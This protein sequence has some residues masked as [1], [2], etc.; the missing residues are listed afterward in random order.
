MELQAESAENCGLNIIHGPRTPHARRLMAPLPLNV[1]PVVLHR[2]P[3]SISVSV[4]VISAPRVELLT[5]SCAINCVAEKPPAATVPYMFSKNG[6]FGMLLG[7]PPAS[8][9]V[10]ICDAAWKYVWPDFGSTRLVGMATSR[11]S[12]EWRESRLT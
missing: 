8:R 1:V 10:P 7:D 2:S 11:F 5:A 12:R 4:V 6:I 9:Y 3:S